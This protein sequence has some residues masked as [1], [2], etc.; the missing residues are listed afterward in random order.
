[1]AEV[2]LRGVMMRRSFEDAGKQ[3]PPA[4]PLWRQILNEPSVIWLMADRGDKMAKEALWF[5][6]HPNVR[7]VPNLKNVSNAFRE[8]R[9]T[10]A[11]SQL[12]PASEQ[13]TLLDEKKVSMA[14][15]WTPP[16]GNLM[17]NHTQN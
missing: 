8:A 9:L 16:L 7:R 3:A 10:E 15:F 14:R 5:A 2:Q 12:H 11:L 17:S 6:E 4:T 13:I 1:M